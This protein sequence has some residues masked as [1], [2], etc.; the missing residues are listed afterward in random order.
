MKKLLLLTV[1]V[2]IL[3]G[4]V[5]YPDYYGYYDTDYYGYP[6]GYVGPNINLYYSHMYSG[7]GYYY[8]GHGFHHGEHGGGWHR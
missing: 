5:V 6:Y 1:M 7:H 8:G 3:G 4:C 2:M